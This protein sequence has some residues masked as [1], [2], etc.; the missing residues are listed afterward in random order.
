MVCPLHKS[1]HADIC[2]PKGLLS[3]TVEF[4]RIDTKPCTHDDSGRP[5]H[6]NIG[7][8]FSYQTL[9]GL[10]CSVEEGPSSPLR[11]GSAN[12]IYVIPAPNRLSFGAGT[13]L[14]AACC[15]PAILS[16]VSM[17]IKILQLNWKIQFGDSVQPEQIHAPL[18]GTNGATIAS[19]MKVNERIKD[20]LNAIGIYVF[21]AVVLA[22]LII[23]EMNFFSRQVKYQ[24]EPIASIGRCQL[25]CEYFAITDITRPMGTNCRCCTYCAG[26][27]VLVPEG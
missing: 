11:G 13:V 17:W 20:F 8:F 6:P 14:A 26:I 19:M 16:L 23:G 9:C 24:T 10:T 21:G 7:N 2:L 15:I 25:F 4:F 27:S 1:L 22:I 5:I 12:N 3:L 18:E